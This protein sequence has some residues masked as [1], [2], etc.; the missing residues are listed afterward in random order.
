VKAKK[1]KPQRFQTTFKSHGNLPL[2]NDSIV[3]L[4]ANLNPYLTSTIPD[5]SITLNPD[6]NIPLRSLPI[7][8]MA[9]MSPEKLFLLIKKLN[10]LNEYDINPHFNSPYSSKSSFS[11]G[12]DHNAIIHSRANPLNLAH[13]SPLGPFLS[14]AIIGPTDRLIPNSDHE[15][16]IVKLVRKGTSPPRVAVRTSQKFRSHDDDE[17]KCPDV[18]PLV[19]AGVG[20]P[21]CSNAIQRR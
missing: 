4:T 19:L 5:L 18:Y 15:Q 13:L 16:N 6:P 7:Y 12:V 21:T 1:S 11:S 3:S 17:S 14:L 20:V 10:L 9:S 8:S 2:A